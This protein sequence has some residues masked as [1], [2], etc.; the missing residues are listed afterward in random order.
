MAKKID[1]SKQLSFWLIEHDILAIRISDEQ[2]KIT[3]IDLE[4]ARFALNLQKQVLSSKGEKYS[5]F[6]I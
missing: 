5:S 6:P 4:E 1:Q 2:A 3:E